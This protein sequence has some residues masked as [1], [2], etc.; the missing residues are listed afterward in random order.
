MSLFFFTEVKK[1]EVFYF[2]DKQLI[3]GS[4]RFVK[5]IIYREG[6]K[7]LRKIFASLRLRGKR[8]EYQK[9]IPRSHS[10][11]QTLQARQYFLRPLFQS[12]FA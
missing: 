7:A 4:R 2:F 1:T 6:A 11:M 9:I 12:I 3:N 10:L 5:G 8:S